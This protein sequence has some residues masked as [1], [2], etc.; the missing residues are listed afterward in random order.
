MRA[1][2]ARA[3]QPLVKFYYA[4]R[5]LLAWLPL[6]AQYAKRTAVQN[7]VVAVKVAWPVS[8]VTLQ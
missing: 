2:W 8:A 5:R 6:V 7:V 4:K 1:V 3:K